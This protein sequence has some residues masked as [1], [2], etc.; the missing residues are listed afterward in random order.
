MSYYLGI[1]IGGTKCAVCFGEIH[2]NKINIVEKRRF[3][4]VPNRPYDVLERLS[5]EA[6]EFGC[7]FDGI[8]I[9]CGGPLDSRTGTIL[10]PPNLP[11][12]DNIQ[13][14]YYFNNRFGVQSYL[15]NDANACAV[16]EWKY[17]AGVG[18]NNMVFLTFGTGFGAGLILNGKLYTGANDMAGEIGHVR[19]SPFGPVG[20]GKAGSVE[21]YCS[22]GGIKRL[23]MTLVEE[24]VQRGRKPLLA[25]FDD[26][27]AKLIAELAIEKNDPLCNEVYRI[28]GEKLGYA[29]AI[30]CDVLDPE[31]IV[32]GSIYARNERLLYEPMINVLKKEAL[33]PCRIVPALL[34]NAIGDYAALA[35]ANGDCV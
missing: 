9:S 21:G 1:D 34:G 18:T 16:A 28:S 33:V 22:G 30:L 35:I 3:A 31:L 23:A 8:G 11:G 6:M 12:W 4:T 15:Q 26:I 19:L 5:S 7:S 14:I 10:S 25:E 27:D 20:Y 32:I 2:D 24:E 17:G 29:L 13:V